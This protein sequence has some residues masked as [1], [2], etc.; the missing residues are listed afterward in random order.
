MKFLIQLLVMYWRWQF[1]TYKQGCSHYWQSCLAAAKWPI[2]TDGV[3]WSV[4]RSVCLLDITLLI[5][6]T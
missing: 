6:W 3:A 1:T 4:C 5:M 2:G